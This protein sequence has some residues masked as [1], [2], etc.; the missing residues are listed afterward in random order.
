M[1]SVM[2]EL[3]V[4]NGFVLLG[5]AGIRFSRLTREEF[6]PKKLSGVFRWL[7]A[8]LNWDWDDAVGCG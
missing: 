8:V 3:L 4:P 5:L 7:A 2:G 6:S 1:G